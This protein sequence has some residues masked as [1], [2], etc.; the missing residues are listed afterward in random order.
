[1][2]CPDQDHPAE[3]AQQDEEIREDLMS[4]KQWFGDWDPERFDF[5]ATAKEFHR[6][7]NY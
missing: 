2:D 1:M 5:E 3:L 4:T 6:R 7:M